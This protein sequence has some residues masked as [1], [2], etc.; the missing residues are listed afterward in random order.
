MFDHP[1]T[2]TVFAD[3]R[4]ELDRIRKDCPLEFVA[5][6]L[7]VKAVCAMHPETNAREVRRWLDEAGKL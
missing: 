4:A 1:F 2:Q 6:D 3:F 7:A 5:V